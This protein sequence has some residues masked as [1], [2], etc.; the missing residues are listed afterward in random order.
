MVSEEEDYDLTRREEDLDEPHANA[1]QLTDGPHA[2]ANEDGID[3]SGVI[4]EG[5]P[6]LGSPHLAP[7]PAPMFVS[8]VTAGESRD[9]AACKLV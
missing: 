3:T 8:P 5:R 2:N 4:T 9:Q 7:R 1:K 6:W